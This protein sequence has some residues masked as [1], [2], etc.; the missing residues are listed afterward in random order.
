MAETA[1]KTAFLLGSSD[2]LAWIESN[3][4]LAALFVL[5]DESVIVSSRMEELR[6][7]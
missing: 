2:G 1:A 6:W 4:L 5:D 7:K 3:H